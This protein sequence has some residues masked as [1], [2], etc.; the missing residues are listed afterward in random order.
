ML[1]SLPITRLIPVTFDASFSLAYFSD[2]DKMLS[3]TANSCTELLYLFLFGYM[4][5]AGLI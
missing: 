2:M 1:D 4:D 3:V 5:I